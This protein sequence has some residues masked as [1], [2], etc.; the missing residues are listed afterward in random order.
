MATWSLPA[1]LR[2]HVIANK[3]RLQGKFMSCYSRDS[4][5][6]GCPLFSLCLGFHSSHSCQLVNYSTIH[7]IH[8]IST[9]PSHIEIAPVIELMR[10]V[11]FYSQLASDS[12]DIWRQPTRPEGL[13]ASLILAITKAF[14]QAM[15]SLEGN[16]EMG[17]KTQKLLC[18]LLHNY[19]W[20]SI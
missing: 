11:C 7:Q 17:E 13:H 16:E 12:T 8:L 3:H 6:R 15:G 14:S 10:C 2:A 5:S 18:H 1:R 4:C 19:C 9:T 20:P